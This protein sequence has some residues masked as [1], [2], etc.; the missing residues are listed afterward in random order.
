MIEKK[1]RGIKEG[2]KLN[3]RPFPVNTIKTIMRRSTQL[4]ISHKGLHMISEHLED[5]MNFITKAAVE[6][7]ERT[8]ANPN[9]PHYVYTRLSDTII[10][11]VLWR[12]KDQTK[13]GK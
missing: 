13:E 4:Q 1:A 7:L 8:N 6:E 2:T 3:I 9:R 5:Y 12:L 10:Q 11:R